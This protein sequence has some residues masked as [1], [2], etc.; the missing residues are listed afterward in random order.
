MQSE[1]LSSFKKRVD[2][3]LLKGSLQRRFLL[4]M[5]SISV[6]TLVVIGAASTFFVYRI[7]QRAWNGRQTE[8]AYFATQEVLHFLRRAEDNLLLARQSNLLDSQSETALFKDLILQDPVLLEIVRANRQGTVVS[9]AAQ[10]EPVL[11]KDASIAQSTWFQ[12]GLQGRRYTGSVRL[13][14]Q[15]EPY[16]ILS[17]PADNGEILATRLRMTTLDSILAAI[18]FGNS[19]RAYLVNEEGQVLAHSNDQVAQSGISIAGRPEFIAIQSTLDKRWHGEYINFQGSPVIGTSHPILGTYWVLITELDAHEAFLATSTAALLAGAMVIISFI[20]L[21]ISSRRV[22]TRMIFIPLERMR[23]GA[24]RV[25]QGNLEYRIELE[26][27]DEIGQV[28]ESFN[29]MAERLE[30]RENELG[31]QSLALAR[32]MF[33][34]QEAAQNLEKLT[35]ELELRVKQRTVDLEREIAECAQVERELR[36]SLARITLLNQVIAAGASTPEP[37]RILDILCHELAHALEIP[38]AA[39]ALYNQELQVMIVVA[40]YL[41]PGRPSGLGMTIPLEGNPSSEFVIQERQPLAIYN[42]QADPRTAAIH[43]KMA[44]RGSVSMLLVPMVI[45]DQ[46]V[47]TLGLDSIEPREFTSDE[48]SLVQS[49]TTAAGQVY[50]NA[51][52]VAAVQMELAERRHAEEQLRYQSTHDSLTGVYNRHFFEAEMEG[53][54]H[55]D[56][57]PVSIVIVDVDRLKRI[58]DTLGHPVGDAYLVRTAKLLQA[59]FRADDVVARIGG[60]EFAVLLPGA[61]S[62]VAIKAFERVKHELSQQAAGPDQPPLGLSL[63]AATCR[64]GGSLYDAYKE[65][66]AQMYQDKQRG[67]EA[68]RAAAASQGTITTG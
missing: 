57:F 4:W 18:R 11:A 14:H 66:D 28:G 47:G 1:R 48:I 27:Q 35:Q 44:A 29:R 15:Q 30:S 60:D 43:D 40:E 49:V 68:A 9:A 55:S 10:G 63:G 61:D 24:E 33:A 45:R 67:H 42:V 41:S 12:E 19:G 51:R 32:E 39:F 22:F 5:G 36:E 37:D 8:A 38:Q 59:S 54:Q 20:W 53:L 46:V 3:W 56:L 34:H 64:K 65:A 23:V 31:Q 62:T 7:E 17:V 26:Q 21:M 52:L 16:L 25:G 50:E 58:N 13:S 2:R 6:L